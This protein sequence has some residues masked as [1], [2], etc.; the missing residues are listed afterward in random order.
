M[1]CALWKA[2]T[3]YAYDDGV[4][5]KG[6]DIFCGSADFCVSLFVVLHTLQNDLAAVRS[7][8]QSLTVGISV[9]RFL[10]HMGGA[11]C[12]GVAFLGF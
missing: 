10:V 3:G 1:D 4:L 2:L 12:N 5:G 6:L 7:F 8:H 11:V 9:G